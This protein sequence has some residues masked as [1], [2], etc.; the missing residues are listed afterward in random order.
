[1]ASQRRLVDGDAIDEESLVD[2]EQMRRGEAPHAQPGHV[3]H[4]RDAGRHASLAAG[5][6]HIA[7]ARGPAREVEPQRT[8]QRFHAVQTDA[9][10]VLRVL[11]QPWC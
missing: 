9:G 6:R 8:C 5:T 10:T 11:G 4:G 2:R 3:K 7:R 1:M